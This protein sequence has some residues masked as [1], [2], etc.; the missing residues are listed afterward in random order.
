MFFN[1]K[2]YHYFTDSW[3]INSIMLTKM[4]FTIFFMFHLLRLLEKDIPM[5][6]NEKLQLKCFIEI[7]FSFILCHTVSYLV[8]AVM[9][10][11]WGKG[12]NLQLVRPWK[13]QE[14]LFRQIKQTFSVSFYI[15]KV[16]LN[17]EQNL[18]RYFQIKDF[19]RTCKQASIIF[20]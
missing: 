7:L 2:T 20:I 6:I 16:I 12:L 4:I 14:I 10:V 3:K 15:V 8:F 19:S 9:I 5:K 13:C 17:K 1:A 18:I 11:N